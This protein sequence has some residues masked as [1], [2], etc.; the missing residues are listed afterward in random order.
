VRRE[1]GLERALQLVVVVQPPP[2][3]LSGA[4]EQS[5]SQ[6]LGCEEQSIKPM[7]HQSG[8]SL[9]YAGKR[10]MKRN[11]TMTQTTNKR[12]SCL[13]EAANVR[14]ASQGSQADSTSQSSPPVQR[15]KRLRW[16]QP[17]SA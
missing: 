7:G 17:Q 1:A 11:G 12:A 13:Q 3:G 4:I 2:L 6:R 15:S 16:Q 10:L 5:Q 9:I 8:H 14:V